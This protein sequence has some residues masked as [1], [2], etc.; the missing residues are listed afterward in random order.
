MYTFTKT[1]RNNLRASTF[2]TKSLLYLAGK[3]SKYKNINVIVIDCFNDV[4]GMCSNERMWDVQAKNEQK[5]TPRKIGTYL[6]TLFDNYTSNFS[7]YFHEYIFFMPRI[8]G[9]YL[10]DSNKKNYDITNFNEEQQTKVI[11]GLKSKLSEIDVNIIKSFINQVQFVEDRSEEQTYIKNL[12]KFR[13]SAIKEDAFFKELFQEI[14][15]KQ[16]GIKNSEIENETI[17]R[18]KDVL[19]YDRYIRTETLQVLVLNRFVGGDIF[20]NKRKIPL[21]YV[22]FIRKFDDDELEDHI[23]SLNSAI[24][25]A[26]FDKNNQK[27]FWKLFESIFRLLSNCEKTAVQ[28]VMNKLD[29][30]TMDRVQH[31]DFESTQFL[32]ALIKDGLK[33]DN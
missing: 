29:E 10:F 4:T 28:Y 22:S 18:P 33:N 30:K 9:S 24:S 32:V 19:A 1:E 2:E 3:S 20:T 15:D 5:L 23:F 17:N 13:P 16:T 27:H 31:M 26:F 11:D 6:I 14:R 7:N 8:N 21:S 12:V 25:K